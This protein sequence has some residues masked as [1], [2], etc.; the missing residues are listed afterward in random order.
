[1]KK[2]IVIYKRDSLE[3]KA[4]GITINEILPSLSF[5]EQHGGSYM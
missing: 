3:N 2:H 5:Y 4:C 1:M